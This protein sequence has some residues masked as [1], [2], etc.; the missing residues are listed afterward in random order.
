MRF[1]K[2]NSNGFVWVGVFLEGGF[3]L[4]NE[5]SNS[6]CQFM[7]DVFEGLEDTTLTGQNNTDWRNPPFH[8]CARLVAVQ[9]E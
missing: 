7:S 8:Y 9:L 2:D 5:R 6:C 4:G 3:W 1:F